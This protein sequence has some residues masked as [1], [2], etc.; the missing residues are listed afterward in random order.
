MRPNSEEVL[1]G[2]QQSLLTYVLPELQ[3]EYARTE[4]MVII[5]LLGIVVGEWDDAAQH[6]LDDNAALRE[7]AHRGAEALASR[8]GAAALVDE[9]RSLAGEVDA[10]VRIPDLSAANERLHDAIGRLGV[11]LQDRDKSEL[12][13]L[14]AAIIERLRLEAESRLYALLG[15]R[16]DG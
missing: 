8:S 15:P 1:R 4:L 16:A 11:F 5:A 3:T 12:L 2:V 6:V 14:R 10:S 9:L 7:L 13:E